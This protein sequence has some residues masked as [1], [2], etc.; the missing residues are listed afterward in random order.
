MAPAN[1]T[2]VT[3]ARFGLGA[4]AL[5]R[6]A[7]PSVVSAVST[8]ACTDVITSLTT[9]TAYWFDMAVDTSNTSN[10]AFIQNVSMSITE[11]AN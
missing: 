6:P 11:L 8:F 10:A 2:A 1:G 7:T 9:G 4:D 3:G 5:I